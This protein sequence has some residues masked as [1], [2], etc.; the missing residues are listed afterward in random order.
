MMNGLKRLMKAKRY[1]KE[2]KEVITIQK[3][4]I[5]ELETLNKN[6]KLINQNYWQK[7]TIDVYLIHKIKRGSFKYEIIWYYFSRFI[8]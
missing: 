8:S 3:K 1:K 5:N 6:L 2:V 7:T 4:A